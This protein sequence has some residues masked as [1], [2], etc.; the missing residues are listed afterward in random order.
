MA[1]VLSFGSGD[2]GGIVVGVS[3]A[4]I[5]RSSRSNSISGMYV[6]VYQR[7]S[8]DAHSRMSGVRVSVHACM[9]ACV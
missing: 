6:Y 8:E 7:K 5:I 1:M 2:D 9:L 3:E 4:R